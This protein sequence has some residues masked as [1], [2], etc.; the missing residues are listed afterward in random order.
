MYQDGLDLVA[1]ICTLTGSVFGSGDGKSCK[2]VFFITTLMV[3]VDIRVRNVTTV[4]Q[5]A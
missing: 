1:K 2:L 5:V 4:Q 3:W